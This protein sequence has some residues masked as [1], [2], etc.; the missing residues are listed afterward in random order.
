MSW[1]T[2]SMCRATAY[3][4]AF[5]VLFNDI[6]CS[7]RLLLPKNSSATKRSRTVNKWSLTL[8]KTSRRAHRCHLCFSLQVSC[9]SHEDAQLSALFRAKCLPRGAWW[10]LGLGCGRGLLLGGGLHLRDPQ[11]PGCLPPG[12][13]GGVRGEQQ[14]SVVGHLHL[15]L[16][17]HL[18]WSVSFSYLALF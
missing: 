6:S 10:R 3:K 5:S 14:P 15:C 11:E 9:C 16:H 18:H 4:L 7:R 17:L 12:S 8:S 1:A 2:L 13:D